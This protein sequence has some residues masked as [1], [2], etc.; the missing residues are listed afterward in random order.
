LIE[1]NVYT[2]IEEQKIQKQNKNPCSFLLD[3]NKNDKPI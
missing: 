1:G 3:M 2:D